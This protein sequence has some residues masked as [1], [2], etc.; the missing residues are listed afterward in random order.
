MFDI[1]VKCDKETY[2]LTLVQENEVVT[3]AIKIIKMWLNVGHK[4]RI[5]VLQTH[6]KISDN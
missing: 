3:D 1:D 5:V 4:T 2:E 6:R